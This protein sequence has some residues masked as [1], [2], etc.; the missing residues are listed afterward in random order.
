MG[1]G[2]ASEELGEICTRI[3]GAETNSVPLSTLQ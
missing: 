1:T 2:V 3:G